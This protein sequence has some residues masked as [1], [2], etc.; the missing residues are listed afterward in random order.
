[1][2]RPPTSCHMAW[3]KLRAY[4]VYE[5]TQAAEALD[6]YLQAHARGRGATSAAS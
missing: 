5:D 1:M 4:E 3:G 6:A 2:R